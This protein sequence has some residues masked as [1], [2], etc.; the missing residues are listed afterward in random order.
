MEV[1]LITGASSGIGEAL[2]FKLAERKHNLLLIARSGDKLEKH[3]KHLTDKF[4]INA[5][6]IAAD[7]SRPDSSNA[8]FEES[9]K[10]NLSVT[11]LVNNAGIGSSGEFVRNNLQ[12]ELSMLQLNNASLVALCHLF[13][14]D[15]IKSKSGS[16]I[17]VASLAAF[18]PSPYMAVYA[19]SK[20]FVR[21]FTQALTEECKPYGVHVLLFSPGFTATNFMNTPANDNAWGKTLTEGAYTQTS[22]QVALEMIQAW[23]KK[24][25]FH[26]S[27]RF[28]SFATKIGAL[29]PNAVIA[30]VFAGS[31]R[32]KMNL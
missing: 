8:V 27:G 24:K 1:T 14:P 21:S 18:F 31:K 7:L 26:V 5:Q 6:Y 4:G 11:M 3:C 29:I 10:R 19:A 16:I 17:N 22:E 32:K 13:L 30:K 28:N 12:S 23:E 25:T 9:K 2:A 15:M 20:V